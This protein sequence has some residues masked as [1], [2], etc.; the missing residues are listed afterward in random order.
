MLIADLKLNFG[1]ES[2][3]DR[4]GAFFYLATENPSTPSI[5]GRTSPLR[6]NSEVTEN[7]FLDTFF[8]HGL[9]RLHGLFTAKSAKIHREAVSIVF[10][11][12]VLLKAGFFRTHRLRPQGLIALI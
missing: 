1:S 2:P 8:N 12:S 9:H 6:V 10:L 5:A 7:F 4:G 11:A 3:V